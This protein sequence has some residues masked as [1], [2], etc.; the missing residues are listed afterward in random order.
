MATRGK[1]LY[2]D[3]DDEPEY[4]ATEK[5]T[6]TRVR[7]AV[8]GLSLTVF[9]SATEGGALIH[10]SLSK[11][12]TEAAGKA[13]TYWARYEGSDLRAQLAGALYL[14]K[15]VYEAVTDG[16]NVLVWTVRRVRATRP[17]EA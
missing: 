3:N 11:A 12:M 7:Q 2:L 14:G 13:G 1:P 10:A 8:S 4:D 15:D 6:A 9:L 16:S 5:A 17:A